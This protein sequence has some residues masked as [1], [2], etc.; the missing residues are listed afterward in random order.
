VNVYNNTIVYSEE[1]G[2]DVSGDRS[3][4]NIFDNIILESGESPI[5]GNINHYNNL[6]SG[7]VSTFNFVNRSS[8]DFHITAD[9]P[10]VDAGSYS[11]C[12]IGASGCTRFDLDNVS[13]PQGARSDIGAYEYSTISENCPLKSEGDVNCDGIIDQSDLDEWK[14]EF[15]GAVS[16]TNSDVNTDGQVDLMDFEIIRSNLF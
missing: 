6:T 9:S 14:A 10:A 8:G 2:I 13:R 12:S 16:T 15:S 11:T 1:E 3:D 7:T 4:S 5:D